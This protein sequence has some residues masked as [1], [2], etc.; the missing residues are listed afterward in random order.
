MN[1][2]LKKGIVCVAKIFR[3]LQFKIVCLGKALCFPVAS[4]FVCGSLN[5]D[6]KYFS[7]PS[8]ALL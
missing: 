5:S 3:M 6:F 4:V 1:F 7:P 2:M 8:T